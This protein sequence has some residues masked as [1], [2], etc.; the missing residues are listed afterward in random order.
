[1]S[2]GKTKPRVG[3]AVSCH[4]CGLPCDVTHVEA[5]GHDFCC[6][7]CRTVYGILSAGGMTRF[8]ELEEAP[9]ATMQGIEA[10]RSFEF[11]DDGDVRRRL[12]DFSDGTHA[13]VTLTVPAIHCIAC[14]WLLENLFRLKPGIGRSEVNFARKTVAIAFDET[15]LKLSEL[16]AF[17]TTIGYEPDLNLGSVDDAHEDKA[18]RRLV[19]QI[20]VAGFAFGNIMLLS[21]PSYLGLNPATE[22]T[23]QGFFGVLSLVISLPVLVFS[24]RD[25]WTS[26][27]LCL[28]RRVITIDFPIAVGLAALFLQSAVHHRPP[29][30][31][32]PRL[33]LGP[34]LPAPC[35]PLVPAS[36]NRQPCVRSHVP[37]LFPPFRVASREGHRH[38]GAD[39]ETRRGRPDH[40]A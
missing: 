37:F 36:H 3:A 8:Y 11:L 40:R 28:R 31:G 18:A 38:G 24:A 26:A 34:R 29:R 1:M 14:V 13:R 23:L 30:R 16:V 39:H 2:R 10:G 22:A 25:Y 9:G 21:F 4:H 7:G 19:T 27:W 12:L 17:L 35:R 20:G 32:V 15:Q 5:D 33:L 6:V